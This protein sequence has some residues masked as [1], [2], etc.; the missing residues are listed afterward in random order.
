MKALKATFQD[1]GI[2]HLISYI[3]I[4]MRKS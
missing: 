1:A 2:L 3:I 4:T